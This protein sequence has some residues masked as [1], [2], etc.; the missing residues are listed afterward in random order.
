MEIFKFFVTIVGMAMSFAYY[1]QAYQMFKNKSANG[2][3][4]L[5]YFI[6]GFGTFVFTIYG[7]LMK[8][9]VLILSFGF[10]VIGSWLVIF[11]IFLYKNKSSL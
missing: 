5:S 7:F 9:I 1:P 6:F 11:L 8:D 10:G 3:S 4:L 2:V